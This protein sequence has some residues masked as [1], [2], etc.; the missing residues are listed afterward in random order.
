MSDKHERQQRL[1]AG[2]ERRAQLHAHLS[3]EELLMAAEVLAD[4]I[5]SEWPDTLSNSVHIWGPPTTPEQME[6]IRKLE[7]YLD[8]RPATA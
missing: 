2:R 8:A 1:E 6:A 5:G 3:P 4:M 7:A